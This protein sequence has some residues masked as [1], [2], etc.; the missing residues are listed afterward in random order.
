MKYMFKKITTFLLFGVAAVLIFPESALGFGITPAEVNADNLKPGSH[1][2]AQVYITRP[3]DES[4][5][6]L[7]VVV[8]TDLGDMESW[9]KFIPGK[10]FVFPIGK[11]TTSFQVI[12]DVPQG[13]DLISYKGQ[14]TAKGLSDKRASEGVTIIKGAVLGVN[15]VA[16]DVDVY[17]LEVL[18][19]TAPDVESGDPVRL[20]LNIENSGNTAVA[21][22]K[23]DLEVMDLFEK[24]IESLSDTSMEKI[25]PFATK[26]VPAEFNSNLE[27]GQYRIDASVVF[28][29]KEIAR[30]KMVLTVNTKTAKVGEEYVQ[31]QEEV[32][33]ARGNYT[34]LIL[35]ALGIFGLAMV[36]LIRILRIGELS[37]SA[38]KNGSAKFL[39]KRLLI[40]VLALV[41]VVAMA[42]AVY[43]YLLLKNP[44]QTQQVVEKSVT[45]TEETAPENVTIEV[46]SQ[47]ASPSSEKE[48]KGASTVG[49]KPASFLV[50][51]K[52]G[53]Q[54]LY[55]VYKEPDFTSDIIYK[56]ENG[57][58]FNVSSQS[59]DW[60]KVVLEDGTSGG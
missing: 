34:L 10:E 9:F 31:T 6:E 39:S 25:D 22:D 52:P 51:N 19:I 15:V 17:D 18:S 33:Q 27:K 21:P 1:Y 57:E 54:G 8:E 26:E 47:E 28:M 29:G 14:I 43:F 37:G 23:V 30:K 48:V 44:L 55:P 56:A 60:Y 53:T 13:I 59:G 5:E 42:V 50:V 2:E 46:T 11:N 41:A 38:L 24:P 12:I 36:S 45:Q 49:E 58:T 40:I 16:S 7:K 35:V 20:L 3:L 4:N 32:P